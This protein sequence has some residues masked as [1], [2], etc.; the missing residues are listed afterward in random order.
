MDNSTG[1]DSAPAQASA[2]GSNL[3]LELFDTPIE[4]IIDLVN[5]DTEYLNLTGW[6][7]EVRLAMWQT[8]KLFAYAVTAAFFLSIAAVAFLVIVN[9]LVPV[10][11]AFCS[12]LWASPMIVIAGILFVIAGAAFGYVFA[13]KKIEAFFAE[14][15]RLLTMIAKGTVDIIGWILDRLGGSDYAWKLVN[16]IIQSWHTTSHMVTAQYTIGYLDIDGNTK[17]SGSA[18]FKGS[19][20]QFVEKNRERNAL[21]DQWNLYFPNSNDL[22]FQTFNQVSFDLE[23]LIAAENVF[24]VLSNLKEASKSKAKLEEETPIEFNKWDPRTWKV[25]SK[26]AGELYRNLFGDAES[27]KEEPYDNTAED[28]EGT[29]WKLVSEQTK[30]YQDDDFDDEEKTSK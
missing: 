17:M 28:D 5:P 20:S 4:K 3:Q 13:W 1:P 21:G 14:A 11:L 16:F 8:G 25:K 23:F 19:G 10:F 9:V 18:K 2:I 15:W 26:N 7:I 29:D 12:L 30:V 6:Q 22:N 27:I 24:E